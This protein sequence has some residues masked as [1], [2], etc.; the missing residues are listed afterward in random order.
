MDLQETWMREY[1]VLPSRTHPMMRMHGA[2]GYILFGTKVNNDK[3]VK[4]QKVNK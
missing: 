4:R 3:G 1:Q 2:S